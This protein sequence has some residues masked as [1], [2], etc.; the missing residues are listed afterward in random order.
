MPGQKLCG[1]AESQSRERWRKMPCPSKAL[2][3]S[4]P[5]PLK[6]NRLLSTTMSFWV[7]GISTRAHVLLLLREINRSC[8]DLR[9]Y[10]ES[11]TVS[12]MALIKKAARTLDP[13]FLQP[14]FLLCLL[15]I[16][17]HVCKHTCAHTHEPQTCGRITRWTKSVWKRR[18]KKTRPSPLIEIRKKTRSLKY[19]CWC[20][21]RRPG[22]HQ[23]HGDALISELYPSTLWSPHPKPPF[24]IC[25]S[26][27]AGRA[28]R[29]QA[30]PT[31]ASVSSL[32]MLWHIWG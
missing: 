8:G 18:S 10:R 7:H 27:L 1:K 25:G 30:N 22:I 20:S 28:G 3:C 12:G 23:P 17:L 26:V 29:G 16:R 21:G 31:G 15:C 32:D 13:L 6:A 19:C 9:V 14:S 2:G 24:F 4:N 5:F 11:H